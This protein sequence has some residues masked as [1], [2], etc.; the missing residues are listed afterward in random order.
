MGNNDGE[1]DNADSSVDKGRDPNAEDARARARADKDNG[2]RT[3]KRSVVATQHKASALG[4]TLGGGRGRK[5]RDSQG[6][7]AIDK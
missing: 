7:C 3:L 4:V 2:D 5:G 6:S 1:E